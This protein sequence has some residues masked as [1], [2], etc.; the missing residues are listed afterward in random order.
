MIELLR[1]CG[2]EAQ[3]I[4]SELPRVEKAFDRLGITAE[5]IER[6]KQRL[7][8]YYDIELKGVRKI[9]GVWVRELVNL[10]LARDEGKKKIIYPAVF[11]GCP[12]LAAAAVYASDDVYA[13]IPDA[14]FQVVLGS[15]FDKLHLIF[16]AAEK[17]WLKAG[18]VNHC[19]HIKTKAGLFALNLLP[20]PDLF[21]GGNPIC[22]TSS[23]SADLLHELYGVPIHTINIVSDRGF[24]EFP[25]VR[26]IGDYFEKGLRQYKRR[27]EEVVGFEITDEMFLEMMHAKDDFARI[28]YQLQDLIEKSDP[29]PINASIYTICTVLNAQPLNSN[30]TRAATEAISTL[31]EEL[32][33]RVSKGVGVVKKGAPRVLATVPT[34]WAYPYL[35]H[36]I[37]E[38][39]IAIAAE[40][41]GHYQPDGRLGADMEEEIKKDPYKQVSHSNFM[42]CFQNSAGGRVAII[43]AICKRTGVVGVIDR[44]HVGCRH[45]IGDA[46]MIRDAVTKELGIPV[47]LM[48]IESFDSRF[49]NT[50]AE[51]YRN[52]LEVFKTMLVKRSG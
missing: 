36:L 2:F 35:E 46:F 45:T 48:E 5:D 27:L 41:F 49:F 47:L 10:M 50:K 7:T 39:G 52:Q 25:D 9:F 30:G 24:D 6:G 20:M 51:L 32:Q 38:T 33:E 3:E 13:V 8:N 17:R 15:I 44:Y 42:T 34:S 22:D 19:A 40:E 43:K 28:T 31:Y 21:V 37:K 12:E 14:L 29:V 4:E 1:L 23:K 26:R 16:E 11:Q 18:K